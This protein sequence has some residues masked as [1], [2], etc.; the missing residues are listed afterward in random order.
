MSPPCEALG[1]LCSSAPSASRAHQDPASTFTK[2]YRRSLCLLQ[3]WLEDCYTVDFT[4]NAGLLGRLQD[5]L[6]SQVCQR[7]GWGG[8]GATLPRPQ[9]IP[10]RFCP[11]PA[12]GQLRGAP[13][14]PPGGGHGAAG[15]G[16]PP[17]RRPGGPQGGR[18]HQ[19]PCRPLQEALGGRWLPEGAAFP[20]EAGLVPSAGPRT[21]VLV[22]SRVHARQTI[23]VH[24]HT[25]ARP[26]HV[27]TCTH[28]P[29]CLPLRGWHS[30]PL[31]LVK[32]NRGWPGAQ[33]TP[34]PSL[35]SGHGQGQK[36]TWAGAGLRGSHHDTCKQ[37]QT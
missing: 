27:H 9:A 35:T 12:P 20:G 30:P 17:Q 15:R 22:G 29:C 25:G 8:A 11:G 24:R 6:S 33:T 13:A 10:T 23:N 3:A 5:Y 32:G 37:A 7:Q 1:T 18:G 16:H 4:R 31:A 26:G 36:V 34:P 19:A 2:I 14:E 28:F 21:L